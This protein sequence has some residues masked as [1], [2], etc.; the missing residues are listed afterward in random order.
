MGAKQTYRRVKKVI[1]LQW[2]GVMVVL[3]LIISVVYF[4]IIFLKMDSNMTE[5]MTD[6]NVSQPW[7][8]CLVTK[9]GDKNK[10]LDDI[11][12][13]ITSEASTLAVLYL[14]AVCTL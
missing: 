13:L 11:A 3:I 5:A 2:R 8:I 6:P 4:A 14:I 12:P 1:A 9:N 10:C 7:L